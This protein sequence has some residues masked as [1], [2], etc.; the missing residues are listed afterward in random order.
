[1]AIL[2]QTKHLNTAHQPGV[3]TLA[4]LN[5][6]TRERFVGVVGPVFEQ[7]P[8]VA[9]RTWPKRPFASAAALHR[10]LCDTVLASDEAKKLDLIRA[11]PDLAGRA[12][13][14]GTLTPASAQE[15]A[16]GGLD[17]L[18][19]EEAALFDK[20]NRAYRERFGFPFVICARRNKKAAVLAGFERRLLHPRAEEIA[21]ALAE[22]FKI[23]ELRLADL[24]IP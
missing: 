13:R 10:A 3:A 19:A 2:T 15:Q 12:A 17:Q 16:S 8:W 20:Y 23:A 1:V 21:A 22:I 14:A 24:I 6:L 18:S 9:E 11:H 5:G 4:A 7:S